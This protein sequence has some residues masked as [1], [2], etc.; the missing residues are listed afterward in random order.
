MLP[1]A[2]DLGRMIKIHKPQT[3]V[4]TGNFT[5][6]ALALFPRQRW[7]SLPPQLLPRP[8]PGANAGAQRSEGAAKAAPNGAGGG[9]EGSEMEGG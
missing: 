6:K 9:L 2:G 4:T 8:Q 7:I 5:F 1:I 3:T